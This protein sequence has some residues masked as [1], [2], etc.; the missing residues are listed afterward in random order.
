MYK[1]LSLLLVFL[2]SLV[3]FAQ[4]E[5]P[6]KPPP[7][8]TPD[9]I[10]AAAKPFLGTFD[11]VSCEPDG[12]ITGLRFSITQA[13]PTD[14]P[15]AKLLVMFADD[16]LVPLSDEFHTDAFFTLKEIDYLVFENGQVAVKAAAYKGK[17][18]GYAFREGS[19]LSPILF[20][21]NT[22]DLSTWTKDHANLCT[23]IKARRNFFGFPEP[24]AETED[25]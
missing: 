1:S 21:K 25:K 4:N 18:V 16:K 15:I 3:A 11:A 7:N 2:L 20:A 12:T 10:E 24:A 6:T 19:P 5:T 22:G 9:K 14:L 23:D 17:L 8:I 13:K